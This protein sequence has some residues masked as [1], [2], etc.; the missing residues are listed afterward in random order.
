MSV[1]SA[2]LM[3]RRWTEVARE[4]AKNLHT[5]FYFIYFIQFPRSQFAKRGFLCCCCCCCAAWWRKKVQNSG[6]CKVREKERWQAETRTQRRHRQMAARTTRMEIQTWVWNVFIDDKKRKK[7]IRW[8]LENLL[9]SKFAVLC[10]YA[11]PL[12]PS[13]CNSTLSFRLHFKFEESST[14]RKKV[15]M[16]FPHRLCDF[17]FSSSF[18]DFVTSL[19]SSTQHTKLHRMPRKCCCYCRL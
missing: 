18:S 13:P 14:V 16:K 7:F 6:R 15:L 9:D 3:D 10:S 12:F 5:E 19:R 1:N 11:D 17:L 4:S 2:K 8:T